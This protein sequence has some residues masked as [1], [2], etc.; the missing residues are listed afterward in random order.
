MP[1]LF[2]EVISLVYDVIG[3]II[4]SNTR[5]VFRICLNQS[6]TTTSG[7]SSSRLGSLKP[8]LLNSP[9]RTQIMAGHATDLKVEVGMTTY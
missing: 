2:P 9:L 4:T 1:V 3:P 8:R 7:K 5:M 6:S